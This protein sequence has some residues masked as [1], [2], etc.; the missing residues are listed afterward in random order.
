MI[1]AAGI[2]TPSIGL[3]FWSALFF[4]IVLVLLGKFAF[5]PI[6]QSLDE[7]KSS[8]ENALA[9]A[10]KA[11]QEMADLT[12]KNENLL[13]EARQERDE[14]LKD[15]KAVATK[16][17]ADA[18][19]KAKE[20]ADKIVKS[21]QAAIETEKKNALKEVKNQVAAMSLD[22]AEKVLRQELSDK[23]AKQSLAE[24]YLKDLNLN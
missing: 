11:K 3:I 8:I 16:M 15:A 19:G 5:K 6:A 17:I 18:E 21:A 23:S 22:L 9:S 2:V 7:R 13:R 1:L 14:I 4:L 12:A 24:G 20:E 10:E